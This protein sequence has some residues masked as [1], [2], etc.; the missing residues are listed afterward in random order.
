[1]LHPNSCVPAAF[2]FPYLAA[3]SFDHTSPA[4][5]EDFEKQGKITP[6]VVEHDSSSSLGK[7]EIFSL[8]DVDPALNAKMHLVNNVGQDLCLIS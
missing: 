8:Q 6:N 3:M 2:H 7:G 1:M 4:V 5:E